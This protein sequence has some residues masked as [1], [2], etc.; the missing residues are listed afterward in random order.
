MDTDVGDVLSI[1][2]QKA[3]MDPA[4][5]GPWPR[6]MRIELGDNR[7]VRFTFHYN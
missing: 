2:C 5:F 6:Q 1:V 4:P 7:D 3:I